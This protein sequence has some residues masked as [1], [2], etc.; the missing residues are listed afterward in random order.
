MMFE[1]PFGIPSEPQ[2]MGCINWPDAFP[3]KPDVCFSIW[4]DGASLHLRYVV[5]EPTVR[6]EEGTPGNFVYKDS[7]VEFF[8]QPKPGDPH[9][10]NFEWNPLGTLYLAWRTGRDDAELAPPEVLSMVKAKGSLG[11][12]PFT[13][14]EAEGPWTLEIEIPAK[15]L[16]HSGIESFAGLSSRANFYKCGDGLTVPHYITWAPIDTP[17]PDYHRPEFFAPVT[18][19]PAG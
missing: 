7:C 16:W 1:V 17:R 11:S 12:V 9:Y 8:F 10:Y 2:A 14:R 15:A 19:A 4:H 3:Q 13:E 18:F 6:A 5:I